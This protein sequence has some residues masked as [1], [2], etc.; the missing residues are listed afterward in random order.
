[1]A[2]EPPRE[3]RR[4]TLV[5]PDYGDYCGLLCASTPTL[6]RVEV[7]LLSSGRAR[8]GQSRRGGRRRPRS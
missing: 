5:W 2:P 4:G 3:A 8:V 7:R 6:S 1:M